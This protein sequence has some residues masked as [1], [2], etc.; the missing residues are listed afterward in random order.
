M[1]CLI[2]W[3]LRRLSSSGPVTVCWD[4]GSPLLAK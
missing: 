4:P 2:A 3:S 1:I